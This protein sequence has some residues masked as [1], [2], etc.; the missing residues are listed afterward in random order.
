M[1]VKGLW[2]IL[3]G[4]QRVITDLSHLKS[5]TI[6]IDASIWMYKY[7]KVMSSKSAQSVLFG[8][9][10]KKLCKLIY[11]GIIPVFVFDGASVPE[12]KRRALVMEFVFF[13][14][15]SF[16]FELDGAKGE[17]GKIHKEASPIGKTLLAAKLR[18]A[19]K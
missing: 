13:S 10:F 19:F 9:M 3:N 11:A 4:T 17:F 7:A 16:S 14:H 15:F 12:L 18:Q 5:K 2:K 6:A 1:G 8:V